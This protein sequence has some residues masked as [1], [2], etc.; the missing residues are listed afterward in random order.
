M[1][2]FLQS[3][4]CWLMNDSH[5]ELNSNMGMKFKIFVDSCQCRAFYRS[6]KSQRGQDLLHYYGHS[7]FYTCFKLGL[8]HQQ[9]FI[10]AVENST[11]HLCSWQRAVGQHTCTDA[12]SCIHKRC[13]FHDGTQRC[14]YA[15][16]ILL[17]ALITVTVNRSALLETTL[18]WIPMRLRK[19]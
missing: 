10:N 17:S 8:Y 6:H 4:V 19:H 18:Q 7:V 1:T 2:Q 16:L 11:W 12:W 13:I 14:E 15:G 5:H 9:L 3:F